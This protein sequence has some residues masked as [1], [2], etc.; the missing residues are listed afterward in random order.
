MNH[1]LLA[2]FL[3]LLNQSF[4]LSLLLFLATV[5]VHQ[6]AALTP[7]A[8]KARHYRGHR[9]GDDMEDQIGGPVAEGQEQRA[10]EDVTVVLVLGLRVATTLEHPLLLPFFRKLDP[11]TKAHKHSA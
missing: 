2:L 11:P 9:E 10:P 7:D 5:V 6:I 4:D 3:C 8:T 1:E